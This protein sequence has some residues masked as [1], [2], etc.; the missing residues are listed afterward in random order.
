MKIDSG[1]IL[2]FTVVYITARIYLWEVLPIVKKQSPV[3]I[4]KHPGR[5]KNTHKQKLTGL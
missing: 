1:G 4:S 2:I 5:Q 3:T